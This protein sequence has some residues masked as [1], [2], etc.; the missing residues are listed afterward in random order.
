MSRLDAIEALLRAL[1]G[2]P[3]AGSLSYSACLDE[4]TATLV[5]GGTVLGDARVTVK[6]AGASGHDALLVALL[7][8]LRADAEKHNDALM[9]ALAETA[10]V[11]L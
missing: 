8:K 5:M 6:V 2:F 9:T 3:G 4:A 1:H 11:S 10:E 7:R